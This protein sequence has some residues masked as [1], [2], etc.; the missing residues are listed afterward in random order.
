M[1]E[2][3]YEWAR[4]EK[5]T[6]ARYVQPQYLPPEFRLPATLNRL[7][8]SKH[9]GPKSIAAQLYKLICKCD[10][11]YDLAPFD[12][13]S[14]VKQMIR[15]PATIL[16][17]K[18]GGCLDLAVL[19]ATMCLGN[20]LL[21]IIIVVDGHAFAGLSLN[22]ERHSM[23][24]PHKAMAWNEGMLTDLSVL[25]SIEKEYLFIECTGAAKSKVLHPEF[26]EGRGR[27]ENGSMSFDRAWEAGTEQISQSTRSENDP[28]KPSQR[29]FLYALDIHELQVTYGLTPFFDT[30]SSYASPEYARNAYLS[31]RLEDVQQ[32]W[33]RKYYVPLSGSGQ[34]VIPLGSPKKRHLPRIYS[35]VLD[36][37]ESPTT[38]QKSDSQIFNTIEDAVEKHKRLMLL[39]APGAGKTTVL[40]KLLIDSLER[41]LR[42][43]KAPIPLFIQLGDSM[44]D[45]VGGVSELIE[46]SIRLNGIQGVHSSELLLL[47]DGLDQIAPRRVEQLRKWLTINKN[48]PMVVS[49][50]TNYHISG[51]TLGITEVKI[52]DLKKEQIED[53]LNAC[54]GKQSANAVMHRLQPDPL[55]PTARDLIYL[56]S[57]PF[58]LSIIADTHDPNNTDPR[59]PSSQ[60]QLFKLYVETLYAR[61]F[62]RR[63]QQQK[64]YELEQVLLG[65]GKVAYTLHFRGSISKS[66]HSG[67][68]RKQLQPEFQ[69][70]S[71]ELWRLGREMSVLDLRN[72]DK[73]VRFTH[74]LLAEY[75]AAEYLARSLNLLKY[76]LMLPSFSNIEH[77]FGRG[78]QVLYMLSGF[79]IPNEVIPIVTS[80]NPFL[81]AECLNYLERDI[82]PNASVLED[83]VLGLANW[84][85][86]KN[87][88]AR[89]VAIKALSQMSEQKHVIDHMKRILQQDVII[90][91]KAAIRVLSNSLDKERAA[92]ALVIALK[93]SSKFVRLDAEDALESVGDSAA[94]AIGMQFRESQ[95][96]DFRLRLLEMVSRIPTFSSLQTLMLAVED[97]EPEVSQVACEFLD[98]SSLDLSGATS[99][100]LN[101]SRAKARSWLSSKDIVHSKSGIRVLGIIGTSEDVSAL[102]ALLRTASVEVQRE[103]LRALGKLKDSSSVDAL[104]AKLQSGRDAATIKETVQAIGLL[105]NPSAIPELQK[106]LTNSNPHVRSATAHALGRLRAA[107]AVSLLI[108]CVYNDSNHFVRTYSTLALGLIG[109]KTALPALIYALKKDKGKVRSFSAMGLGLLCEHEAIPHLVSQLDDLNHYVR[110][111]AVCALALFRSPEACEP[112]TQI[113]KK[114]DNEHVRQWVA[115]A[116]GV[117]GDSLGLGGLE[118]AMR[119]RFSFVRAKAVAAL[120]EINHPRVPLLLVRFAQDDDDFVRQQSIIGL[121]TRKDVEYVD[122]IWKLRDDPNENVR[123][124]HA[125]T[126]GQLND[127]RAVDYLVELSQRDYSHIVRQR[128]VE[129]LGNVGIS[130]LSISNTLMHVAQQDQVDFVRRVAIQSLNKL[131]IMDAIPL[132]DEL[133]KSDPS[134][135]VRRE[136]KYARKKIEEEAELPEQASN[137]TT[138]DRQ[139]TSNPLALNAVVDEEFL[140]AISSNQGGATGSTDC[141]IL[142]EQLESLGAFPSIDTLELARRQIE[143][144]DLHKVLEQAIMDPLPWKREVAKQALWSDPTRGRS[145]AMST[146]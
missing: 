126:I 34:E 65:L 136:A 107:S 68:A 141:N 33:D 40:T 125:W 18:R 71:D 117:I 49:C 30:G 133:A 116:L 31:S 134:A 74:D 58:F 45:N 54:L 60:G 76:L 66:M 57:N 114:D 102:S 143:D 25:H 24:N 103:V 22:R 109:D 84:L 11:N 38:P 72:N 9:E 6:L 89:Q 113:I 115:I 44:D 97:T 16:S 28:A 91:R 122:D 55:R 129:A 86:N 36:R 35:Q 75:F 137:T 63:S 7:D 83:V 139:E 80:R 17:E 69:T 144:G 135:Y 85:D 12:A 19:F 2:K 146:E 15:P 41:A 50:R 124:A 4:A 128:A 111:F 82:R 105:R 64:S 46:N 70:E 5:R 37:R 39:G 23:P 98:I 90:K 127:S 10:I 42:E 62:E 32:E 101:I 88:D 78:D 119:D 26:P 52:N 61:Q 56:A 95:R 140:F 8:L 81:A 79:G 100:Q 145:N 132:L 108:D 67:W 93:D 59:I 51:S 94:K 142:D 130:S 87:P 99:D 73:L 27:Q 13:R 120:K 3:Y 138:G 110:Q 43:P 106:T 21:P 96:S 104:I 53:F 131:R 123:A 121:G 48:V 29:P 77:R 14:E 20:D 1:A 47:L 112:L 118:W 92:V